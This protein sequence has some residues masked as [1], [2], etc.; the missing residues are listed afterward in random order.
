MTHDELV[1]RATRWLL[2][3]RR[4]GVV[5]EESGCR[6]VSEIP[7]AIGW[8]A[9][10]VCI[11]V[12]C[13]ASVSDFYSDRAKPTRRVPE[14]LGLG[15]ER[16]YMTEP[17]LLSGRKLPEGWG[18][19]EVHPSMVRRKLMAPRIPRDTGRTY[20]E[21]QLLIAHLRWWQ[22]HDRWLGHTEDY[23]L[24]LWDVFRGEVVMTDGTKCSRCGKLVDMVVTMTLPGKTPTPPL[25]SKCWKE[26][27]KKALKPFVSGVLRGE[28]GG[29]GEI[30][31]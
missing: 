31:R 11:L 24:L 6:V 28:Q 23:R 7:D 4:C 15:D 26:G 2:N 14:C 13:K 25:C 19:L 5:F 9:R 8:T 30:R 22:D 17:G 21:M 12:E 3:S 10:G 27:L 29:A 18:L 1:S 20:R 16:W